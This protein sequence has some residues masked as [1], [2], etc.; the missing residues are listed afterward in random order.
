M[1]PYRTTHEPVQAERRRRGRW[2]WTSRRKFAGIVLAAVAFRAA[3]LWHD[4]TRELEVCAAAFIVGIVLA[5]CGR[6]RT[7]Y[8]RLCARH[9]NRGDRLGAILL[10]FNVMEPRLSLKRVARNNAARAAAQ[11]GMPKVRMY[12]TMPFCGDDE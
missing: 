6:S 12:N 11:A 3:G 2:R 8:T 4:T 5:V 7:P 9:W 1:S 10:F